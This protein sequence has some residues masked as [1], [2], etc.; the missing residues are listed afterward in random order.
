MKERARTVDF[1][2]AAESWARLAFDGDVLTA[3][4]GAARIK[5]IEKLSAIGSYPGESLI[6]EVS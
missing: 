4:D 6:K 1:R 5:N 2:R 3:A